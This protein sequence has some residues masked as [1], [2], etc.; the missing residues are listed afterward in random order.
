MIPITVWVDHIGIVARVVFSVIIKE[1]GVVVDKL[2]VA[3]VPNVYLGIYG[4]ESRFGY[5]VIQIEGVAGRVLYI[6]EQ[7]AF[8]VVIHCFGIC[9]VCFFE[10]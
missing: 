3:D 9:N 5:G 10:W 2:F 8:L 4:T 6:I 1:N 7:V